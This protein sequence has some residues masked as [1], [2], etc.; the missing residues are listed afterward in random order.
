[1]IKNRMCIAIDVTPETCILGMLSGDRFNIINTCIFIIRYVIF[2]LQNTTP[3]FQ[4]MCETDKV[5]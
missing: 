1:M 2:K 3:V 5:L 4:R